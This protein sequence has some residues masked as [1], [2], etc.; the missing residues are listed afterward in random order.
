MTTTDTTPDAPIDYRERNASLFNARREAMVELCALLGRPDGAKVL[1]SVLLREAGA[2]IAALP[3]GR[4][5]PAERQVRKIE[6]LTEDI[7]L[8]NYGLVRDYVSRFSRGSRASVEDFEGAGVVGLMQA[9]DSYDPNQGPFGSWAFKP[10]KR[11]VLKAVRDADHQHLSPGDFERRPDIL[12]AKTAMV[13][14]G[15]ETPAVEDVAARAGVT[16]EQARR[17]LE[18]ASLT[19]LSTPVGDGSGSGSTLGEMLSDDTVNPEDAV[20]AKVAVESLE[21]H[22]LP[23]LNARELFVLCRRFGIDGEPE[24]KLSAIGFVLGLS[25]EAV[26]NVEAKA[27][28][29]LG[30]PA[31]VRGILR[32]G[33]A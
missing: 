1:P 10:I 30:H 9:I 6:R 7:V 22:G 31:T 20:L 4:R 11:S 12:K 25:R 32:S 19:S 24:A 23:V 29:K 8:A 21:M 26:R 14:A 13:D 18:P 27:L 17:V 16:V 28:A 5:R 33:R 2:A 3:S 15:D